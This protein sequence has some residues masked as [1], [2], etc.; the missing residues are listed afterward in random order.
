MSTPDGS[1]GGSPA[2]AET[3]T[4][5]GKVISFYSYRGG[6]GRSMAAANVAILLAK[7]DPARKVL[8]VDFD[9]SAP[10]QHWLLEDKFTTISGAVHSTTG[11][12]AAEPGL[13]DII[14]EIQAQ[15]NR[16]GTNVDDI[17]KNVNPSAFC[18]KSDINGLYLMKSGCFD[19]R[20][21]SKVSRIDWEIFGEHLIAFTEALCRDFDYVIVDCAAGISYRALAG[22]LL[23]EKAVVMFGASTS[24]CSDA[25]Q[26]AMKALSMRRNSSDLRP[27]QVYP[28]PARVPLHPALADR[29]EAAR[30]AYQLA[31]EQTLS[32]AYGLKDLSLQT[33]FD[34]VLIGE[35]SAS[36]LSS[37]LPA[38]DSPDS[39]IVAQYQVLANML[40]QSELPYYPY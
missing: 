7:A 34:Q 2:V 16:R 20:F 27:F 22:L 38:V 24:Q 14:L 9:L 18:C 8:V 39:A 23:S 12:I 5:S 3:K 40:S 31:F 28:V 11:G 19:H 25:A 37:D 29:R 15:H 1:S 26:Q 36:E 21:P 6:T 33:Y 35:Y 13:V 32:E 4:R 30:R 17:V 10:S